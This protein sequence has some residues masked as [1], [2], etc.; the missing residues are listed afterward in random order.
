MS[1]QAALHGFGAPAV[2]FDT[3]FE[4]LKACHER[5]VRT[6]ALQARLIDHLAT[7]GCDASARSAAQ[8]VLRYFDLAEPLHHEDEELHV[9][10][11]LAAPTG[12]ELTAAVARLAAEHTAMEQR[13]AQARLVLYAI[14]SGAA[15]GEKAP[16]PLAEDQRAVL[17]AFA[18]AYAPHIELEERLVYPAAMARM[19]V[20]QLAAMGQD[21][22]RRRG[23]AE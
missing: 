20:A 8:D 5:V 22:R 21:M 7:H 11:V 9:F 18:A 16:A 23:A 13:W 14:A 12:G 4:M 1:T 3:P 19:N 6:L 10:P 2:G 17:E 15:G